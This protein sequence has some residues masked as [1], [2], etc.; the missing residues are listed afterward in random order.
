MPCQKLLRKL[1]IGSAEAAGPGSPTQTP[2]ATPHCAVHESQM[3]P[4]HQ[5]VQLGHRSRRGTPPR[6]REHSRGLDGDGADEHVQQL[7]EHEAGVP[8]L[9][10][11]LPTLGGGGR[12]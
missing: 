5:Q 6:G 9:L 10:L 7:R 11:T 4:V 3:V 8:L 2:A 1:V 12:S